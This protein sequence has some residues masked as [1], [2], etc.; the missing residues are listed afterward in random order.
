MERYRF[1]ANRLGAE[2]RAAS[3]AHD[4]FLTKGAPGR[5]HVVSYSDRI[6]EPFRLLGVGLLL[7]AL[8]FGWEG[9]RFG[10][11]FRPP[12]ASLIATANARTI[13]EGYRQVLPWLADFLVTEPIK[14][15]MR[16]DGLTLTEV[17]HLYGLPPNVVE[18][19]CGHPPSE[20]SWEAY[21]RALWNERLAGW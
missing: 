5:L 13:R 15:H 21:E 19:A 6:P 3:I 20:R 8:R 14:R 2:I 16:R 9:R 4:V 17:C 11:R 10:L 1:L 12:D 7:G 18:V